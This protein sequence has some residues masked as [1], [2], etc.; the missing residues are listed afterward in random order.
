MQPE[1]APY[2]LIGVGF[3]PSNLAVAVALEERALASGGETLRAVFF[4]RQA[5]PLWH[6]G[7]LLEG[8]TLQISFLKDLA[9]PRDPR[10]EFTFLNYLREIGRLQAFINL[11]DFY[12]SRIEF[13]DYLRWAAERLRHHAR[14]S[15]TVERILPAQSTETA[16]IDL[17]DVVVRHEGGRERS[18]L[19]RNV[20]VATGGSPSLPAGVS[21]SEES[22][23]VHSSQF[24]PFLARHFAERDR[25][26]RFLVIGS[27]QSAAEVYDYLLRNFPASDVACAMRRWAFK[28]ADDSSFVNEIFRP[29]TTDLFY[30]LTSELRHMI[31]AVHRDTNYSAVDL[32]LIRAIYRTL[33]EDAVEGRTRARLLPLHEFVSLAETGEGVEVRLRDLT[34]RRERLVEA[35]GVVFATGYTRTLPLPLLSAIDPYIEVD[36]TGRYAIR[37]DYGLATKE[38]LTAGV[39]LQG[40]AEDTHGL[41]D[42]LLSVLALRSTDILDSI[43]SRTARAAE[44]LYAASA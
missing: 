30:G 16:E 32:D 6:P 37:R 42:T 18:H 12:P 14:F 33:Y 25:P 41:S 17:L 43:A 13:N 7:L 10:S 27:G 9:T 11:R 8:T 22:R 24:V 15:S 2:D 3:G 4:E 26:H 40:F 19:T 29:E 38:E 36:G 39:Y 5:E 44:P 35:D 20:V 28:P 34:A 1:R 31:S 21:T 23:A